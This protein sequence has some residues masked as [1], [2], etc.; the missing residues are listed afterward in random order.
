MSKST[1]DTLM[2]VFTGIIAICALCG[3]HVTFH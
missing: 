1:K 3:M 2:V